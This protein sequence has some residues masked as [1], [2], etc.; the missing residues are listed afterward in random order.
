VEVT[1]PSIV[2]VIPLA[3]APDTHL[4]ACMPLPAATG[5]WPVTVLAVEFWFSWIRVWFVVVTESWLHQARVNSAAVSTGT[6]TWLTV[7]AVDVAT[8]ERMRL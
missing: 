3:D 2:A 4:D 1:V 5:D 8:D 7:I 6:S